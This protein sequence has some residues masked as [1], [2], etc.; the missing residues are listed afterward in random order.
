MGEA[1]SF[2]SWIFRNFIYLPG[3]MIQ[4]GPVAGYLRDLERSQWESENKRSERQCAALKRLLGH[5]KEHVPYY[6]RTLSR[7]DPAELRSPADITQI[8]TLCKLD[9]QAHRDDL[10]SRGSVGRLI[11]KTTGGS[12]G[13]PV[14]VFKTRKALAHE[15]AATWRGYR[16]AG[17]NMGDRQARFWGVPYTQSARRRARLI[18]L[19][20]NRLRL[21]AFRFGEED[22][23]AGLALI[24]SSRPRYFY[25][26]VSMLQEFAAFLR[27]EGHRLSVPLQCVI[28]TSEVLADPVRQQLAEAFSAPVFDEYG[29][30]ELGTIAHECTEGSRHLSEENMIVEI[31]DGNRQCEVGELGEIVVTELNNLGMPL[32]RYR[33]GDFGA[34]GKRSCPCGRSL[35]VLENLKGRAYD[36]IVDAEGRRFHGEFV[37]YI[38][39]EIRRRGPGIRQFQCI[40][41]APDRFHVKV[42][43]EEGYSSEHEAL[44]TRRFRENIHPSAQ[45][46]FEYVPSIARERSGK[47]RLIVGLPRTDKGTA[48]S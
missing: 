44:I 14:T 12:T 30:G 24:E 2:Q 8:P 19:V 35:R 32:I 23:R 34:I 7:I 13:E 18:D 4:A 28:T 42:V 20:C 5:A 11:G 26:Y 36:F 29:C 1:L 31:L 41:R 46:D 16:W 21:S 40:Q 10:R 45:V 17:V 38:F 6:A 3:A 22:L 25:G 27:R 39:E 48:V 9:L 33:T 47:M 15:L 37:L 43:R